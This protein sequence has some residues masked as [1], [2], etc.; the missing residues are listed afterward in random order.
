VS[1]VRPI[2]EPNYLIFDPQKGHVV[3]LWNPGPDGYLG[4]DTLPYGG[5]VTAETRIGRLTVDASRLPI[6]P[7]AASQS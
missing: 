4:R 2:I 5:K 1:T 3:T 6:D 7:K